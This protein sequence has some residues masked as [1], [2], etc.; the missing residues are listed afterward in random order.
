M[1]ININSECIFDKSELLVLETHKMFCTCLHLNQIA[2]SI[3]NR[4]ADIFGPKM[5]AD[6]KMSGI[7]LFLYLLA[8]RI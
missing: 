6:Q 8:S 2:E 7:R 1:K 5:I 4:T 3:Y